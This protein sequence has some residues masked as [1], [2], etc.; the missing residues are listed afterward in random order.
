M[1]ESSNNTVMSVPKISILTLH[2]S[3]ADLRAMKRAKPPLQ[4]LRVN[5]IDVISL[6]LPTI[7]M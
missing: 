5:I 2:N 6:L 7:M 3:N 4:K 1:T